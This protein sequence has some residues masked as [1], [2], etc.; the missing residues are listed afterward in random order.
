MPLPQMHNQVKKAK[1]H[2]LHRS[3]GSGVN[4]TQLRSLP[5][6]WSSVGMRTDIGSST[7]SAE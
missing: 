7:R 3:G 2:R 5:V 6:L 1:M 4:L